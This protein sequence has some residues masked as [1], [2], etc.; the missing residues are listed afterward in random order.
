MSVRGRNIQTSSAS[1]L[2]LALLTAPELQIFIAI[3]IY[4]GIVKY[5]DIEIYWE[6]ELKHTPFKYLSLVRY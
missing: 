5:S 1:A 4:M 2:P 6:P 3:Q